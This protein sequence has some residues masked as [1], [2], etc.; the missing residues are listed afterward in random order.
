[1]R[2]NIPFLPVYSWIGIWSSALLYLS[3]FFSTSNVVEYFTRFTDDIFSSLISVIFIYEAVY[4]LA[5]GFLSPSVSGLNAGFST[6]IALTTFFTANTLSKIRKSP[7]LN[8]SLR[9]MVFQ[10]DIII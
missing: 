3:A 2:S 4:N 6:I 9:E 1:M 10:Y 8:R 5:K 7:Y